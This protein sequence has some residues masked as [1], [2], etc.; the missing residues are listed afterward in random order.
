MQS[1][2]DN[3][4]VPKS[5]EVLRKETFELACAEAY[6]L[7]YVERADEQDILLVERERMRKAIELIGNH[8][9]SVGD[10]LALQAQAIAKVVGHHDR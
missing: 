7:R 9:Y 1:M 4:K 8:P 10:L 3:M 5:L 6:R 2:A